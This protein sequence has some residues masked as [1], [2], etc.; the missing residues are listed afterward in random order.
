MSDKASSGRH[1]PILLLTPKA[2]VTRLEIEAAIGLIAAR[3]WW[4]IDFE[5]RQNH[6][7]PR[8]LTSVRRRRAFLPSHLNQPWP[9][10]VGCTA[11][12]PRAV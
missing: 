1:V 11:S 3:E 7:G 12:S 9:A 2:K 6:R 5:P 10:R 4:L 8:R